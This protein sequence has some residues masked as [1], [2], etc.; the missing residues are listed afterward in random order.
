[1][2]TGRGTSAMVA[3]WGMPGRAKDKM[4]EDGEGKGRG[5]KGRAPSP[6]SPPGPPPSRILSASVSR[7]H[8]ILDVP[9]RGRA[10]AGGFSYCAR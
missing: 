2:K 7:L 10:T 6:N 9:Y 1:M 8:L 3:G 4:E 5:E